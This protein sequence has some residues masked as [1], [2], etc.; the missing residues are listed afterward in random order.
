MSRKCIVCGIK[1]Y[2]TIKK[3][4]TFKKH[5]FSVDK[6]FNELEC[7]FKNKSPFIIVNIHL[8]MKRFDVS[9][10]NIFILL[11]YIE[12]LNKSN[13][14]I[15]KDTTYNYYY[16]EINIDLFTKYYYLFDNLNKVKDNWLKKAGIQYLISQIK[17]PSITQ[18]QIFIELFYRYYVSSLIDEIKEKFGINLLD[19]N[20]FHELYNWLDKKGYVQKYYKKIIF[21]IKKEANDFNKSIKKKDI[22]KL[23]LSIKKKSTIFSINKKKFNEDKKRIY[24]DKKLK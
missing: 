19:F 10:S 15:F 11:D 7:F 20:N 17:F 9:E 16:K 2:E 18:K 1:D 6:Y 14:M 3:N 13:V 23:K 22:E 5:L 4:G 21:D 12:K 24:D 8:D